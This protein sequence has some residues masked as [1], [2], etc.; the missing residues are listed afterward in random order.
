MD[1]FH[2]IVS[3]VDWKYLRVV[4]DILTDNAMEEKYHMLKEKLI[5]RTTQ[6]RKYGLLIL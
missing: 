6:T 5:E 4:E 1:R 2:Y 3:Q